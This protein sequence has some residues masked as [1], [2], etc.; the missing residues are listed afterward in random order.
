MRLFGS[1]IF[2]VGA[3]SVGAFAYFPSV[4]AHR[5]DRLNVIEIEATADRVGSV[6]T[7]TGQSGSG[8]TGGARGFSPAKSG[9]RQVA[10][11]GAATLPAAA[12]APHATSPAAAAADTALPPANGGAWRTN[13]TTAD[14]D[15]D[16]KRRSMSKPSDWTE[17]VELARSLQ[18][19]LKRVGCY[20]GTVDG[21]W[22]G[23]SKRA[24]TSFLQKVNA[25]LPV[26]APDYIL[27]TLLQGHA[28]K[29]CGVE[30]PGGQG[31]SA[32]GRCVSNVIV[33]HG[34]G[35]GSLLARKTTGTTGASGADRS[36]T[37]ADTNQAATAKSWART[38]T[39]AA[40]AA[41]ASRAPAS[42]V[43]TSNTLVTT[44]TLDTTANLQAPTPPPSSASTNL[45]AD[46]ASNEP[47]ARVI[48]PAPLPGRMA[49][50]A[51]IPSEPGREIA[52]PR[53]GSATA[54]PYVSPRGISVPRSAKPANLKPA[55]IA[56]LDKAE[57][58]PT[59]AAPV[60]APA[61][62]LPKGRRD[63]AR[64][65]RPTRNYRQPVPV[66]EYRSASRRNDYGTVRTSQGKV[67]RGSPAHNLMLS[68][69]G[70][71]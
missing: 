9:P 36:D 56:S 41:P 46:A 21:D 29:A 61:I 68:L 67:R 7:V 28:D 52:V 16:T 14:S 43:V 35:R 66:K 31:M 44:L 62:A 47:A 71:F 15:G 17:R 33:A 3:L 53:A 25:T 39:V 32:D 11:A 50:G 4:V 8:E 23:A 57:A 60:V 30:C 42:P 27:L 6:A 37:N 40:I 63:A 48:A 19:E 64:Q 51:P 55:A 70:V 12:T 1:F 69:G 38:T 54:I 22:G 5:Q 45:T 10:E 34:P 58:S 13:V 65:H 2:L 20:S 59:N 24:M 18:S 49:I 26:E